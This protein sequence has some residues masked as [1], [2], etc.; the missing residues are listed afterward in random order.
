MFM[1]RSSLCVL[2]LNH[3]LF[4]YLLFDNYKDGMYAHNV[5]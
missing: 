4:D 1:A 5:L 3:N 2:N